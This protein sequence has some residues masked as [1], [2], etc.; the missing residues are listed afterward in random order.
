MKK[1][2]CTALNR[3]YDGYPKVEVEAETFEQACRLGFTKLFEEGHADYIK[4]MAVS[5]EH[6]TKKPSDK[7]HR[8]CFGRWDNVWY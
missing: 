7:V 1:Y 4:T 8:K 3:Q 2:I 6:K 5:V